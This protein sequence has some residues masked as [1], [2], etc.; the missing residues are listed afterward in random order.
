MTTNQTMTGLDYRIREM[1][2]RIRE[3]REITGY[4]TAEMARRTAVSEEEYQLCESGSSDLNFAFLY[5]CALAFGVDVTELIEGNSPKLRA[6]TVTRAGGGQKIAQAHEMVYYNMAPG[7]QNRIADPLYTVSKYSDKAFYSDIE[8]TTHIGQECDLVIK[9]SLKV[10][11]GEHTELLYEGD[12]IYYDSSIP[13]G[14]VAA[15]GEDCIFYAIVLHTPEVD[16]EETP[17]NETYKS[18]AVRT[19]DTGAYLYSFY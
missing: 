5:R 3:L 6:Y 4:T 19:Q 12:C 14:M 8:L 15:G 2:G 11:V 7:F 16:P 10:Q 17:R 13:H 18:E 1:A 9:G